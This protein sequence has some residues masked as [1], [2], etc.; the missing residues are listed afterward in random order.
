M[1]NRLVRAGWGIVALSAGILAAATAGKADDVGSVVVVQRNV[2]GTPPE[3]PEMPKYA[4]NAVA[5]REVIKTREESAA[6]IRFI[7]GSKLTVG[8][9]SVIQLDEFVFDPSKSAG[10]AAISVTSGA[11]RFITG[12]M[13]KGN[14]TI[15]TPTATMVLRGTEVTVAV[16]PDGTTTLNVISGSVDTTS[17][18]NS[19]HKTVNPGHSVKVGRG[20]FSNATGGTSNGQT[21]L[22]GNTETGDGAVDSGLGGSGPGGNGGDGDTDTGPQR[23][24]TTQNS[25]PTGAKNSGSG[26]GN[27]GGL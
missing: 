8:A 14:T 17:K 10:K 16:A 3:K 11:I 6:L 23:T 9:K 25:S 18:G 1:E 26:H 13:P 21:E 5:Y 24:A 22:G 7:D 15:D 2:Y 4:G 12:A 27:N 19:E 20:G